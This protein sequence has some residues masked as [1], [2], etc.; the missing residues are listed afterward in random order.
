VSCLDLHRLQFVEHG[1]DGDTRLYNSARD[2]V[3]RVGDNESHGSLGRDVWT[4]DQARSVALDVNR[5][6]LYVEWKVVQ[7]EVRRECAANLPR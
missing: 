7:V 4:R 3:I 6:L 1:R 2:G 5:Q